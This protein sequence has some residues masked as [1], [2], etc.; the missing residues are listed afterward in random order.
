MEGKIKSSVQTLTCELPIKERFKQTCQRG[1]LNLDSKMAELQIQIW[2]LPFSRF[3]SYRPSKAFISPCWIVAAYLLVLPSAFP[4]KS[5]LHTAGRFT[6][7][8]QSSNYFSH[9]IK[10]KTNSGSYCLWLT[11][12][13]STLSH[14]RA[15]ILAPLWYFP[16]SL[17]CPHSSLGLPSLPP[18][19]LHIST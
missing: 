6:P 3:S 7:L 12:L 18:S 8:K 4:T 19:L 5:V 2:A 10:K 14:L 16:A 1:S 15:W 11:I 13:P 9:L 17:I